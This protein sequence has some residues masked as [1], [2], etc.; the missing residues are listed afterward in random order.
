M[1]RVTI[2]LDEDLKRDLD[3]YM[4]SRSYG[5]R[6]EAIRDLV[7]A[8]IHEAGLPSD[9]KAD[10]LAALIYVY[11]HETREL[12]KKL[13]RSFHHRHEL[14]L[15]TLHVHLDHDS[16]MEVSVLK[17]PKEEVR[18]FAE[19]VIAERGV[20]HGNVVEVPLKPPQVSRRKVRKA[21]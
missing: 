13:A 2:T 7:R 1:E 10:C 3:R 20:R 21:R 16:C 11:D 14:S 8:G 5:N 6:S 4:Q 9:G 18:R 12:P 15:A 19:H 17:G